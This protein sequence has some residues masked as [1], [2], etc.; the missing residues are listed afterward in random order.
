MPAQFSD[1]YNS[2][3]P[4]PA[5]R[6]KQF[7][8]F[9]KWFLKA[10]PEWATQ[11]DQVWLCESPDRR[12]EWTDVRLDYY[13]SARKLLGQGFFHSAGI[14]F[15]YAVE[16][17]LQAALYEFY[18]GDQDRKVGRDILKN[19]KITELF[20]HYKNLNLLPAIVVSNDFLIFVE[21]N[22][23]R[24][25]GQII[26]RRGDRLNENGVVSFGID[27]I[28][29]YDDLVIQLDKNILEYTDS[30]DSSIGVN[31]IMRVD[32]ICRIKFFQNNV[33][34]LSNIDYYLNKTCC[35]T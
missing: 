35:L 2:L 31:A 21:D 4:D 15:A 11:V 24:Y 29:Y 27:G 34:A 18:K 26:P 10:D 12:R 23:Q 22:F 17:H 19:H 14:L 8:H 32:D 25:P 6:G 20:N 28:H 9:V 3:D 33:H 13:V 1:F 30:L 5:R 7:E 16:T